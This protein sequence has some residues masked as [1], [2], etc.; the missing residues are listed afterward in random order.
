METH[1]TGGGSERSPGLGIY[2]YDIYIY[3][4]LSLYIYI[5]IHIDIYI[6]GLFLGKITFT[7]N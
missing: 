7:P 6:S 3:I 5:Y 4:S 2:M 1:S